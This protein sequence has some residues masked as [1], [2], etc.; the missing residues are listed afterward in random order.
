MDA[1]ANN[2]SSDGSEG[3]TVGDEL[4]VTDGDQLET[5]SKL[6]LGEPEH[7]YWRYFDKCDADKAVCRLCGKTINRKHQST[8]GI[9]THLKSSHKASWKLLDAARKVEET[10]ST[11]RQREKEGKPI[12]LGPAMK[13]LKLFEHGGVDKWPNGDPKSQ[14]LDAAI[15]KWMMLNLRP[16]NAT[17]EPGFTE[18]MAAAQPRYSMHTPPLQA[19]HSTATH[20]DTL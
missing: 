11:G 19:I 15:L 2:H 9:R 14:A 7:S 3:S 10:L 8:K 13:Q 6:N 12:Q 5:E 20:L 4:E 17:E 1:E 18:L 16:L